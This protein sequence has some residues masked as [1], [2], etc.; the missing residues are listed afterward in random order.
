MKFQI[1]L[2]EHH[3]F[4]H[5]WPEGHLFISSCQGSASFLFQ[6]SCRSWSGSLL[7]LASYAPRK[8]Q[9]AVPIAAKEATKLTQEELKRIDIDTWAHA[10]WQF[11]QMLTNPLPGNLTLLQIHTSSFALVRRFSLCQTCSSGYLFIPRLLPYPPH[12]A[13]LRTIALLPV[14][15]SPSVRPRIVH[16]LVP[17]TPWYFLCSH[18]LVC[19]LIRITYFKVLRHTQR[20]SPWI[21]QLKV[22]HL[23]LAFSTPEP[24]LPV[25]SRD[26]QSYLRAFASHLYQLDF[27]HPKTMLTPPKLGNI[28]QLKIAHCHVVLSSPLYQMS[29][30]HCL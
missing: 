9:Q 11:E 14:S 8:A 22:A 5:A 6:K 29:V 18:A 28:Y 4:D 10:T 7:F 30:P 19:S 20:Y 12:P 26:S 15:S 21:Y 27:A 2:C 17:H 1:S 25:Y 16:T 13:L 23:P 24:H 3:Q